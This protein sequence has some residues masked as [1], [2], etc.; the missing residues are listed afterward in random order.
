[1]NAYKHLG[2]P[3][4]LLAIGFLTG[5]GKSASG[6]VDRGNALFNDGKFSEAEINYRKALQKDSGS[7]DASYHLALSLLKQNKPQEAYPALLQ[8]LRLAPDHAGARAE[9]TSLALPSYV[10]DE[11]HPKALYDV[12]RKYSAAW[13]AKDPRSVD[14]LRIKAYLAMEERRPEE[15]AELFRQALESNPKNAKLTLGL[16]DALYRNKQLADAEK[17]GLNFILQDPAAGDVYDALYR[18]YEAGNRADDAE[19]I[20]IRKVKNNPQN[21]SYVLEL[22]AHYAR[23]RQKPQMDAA[24][25]SFLSNPAGGLD[26]HLQAGDFYASLGDWSAAL[27]QYNAG[28]KANPKDAQRYQDRIARSLISQGKNDEGLKA[29]NTAIGQN[30]E[31]AE[32][33]A[34][35]AA[36]LIGKT[37]GGKPGEGLQEFQ[38]LVD[39]N[40]D[41]AFLRFVYSK[42]QLESGNL[43]GAR[44]QL[45]ELLKRRP[46]FA[47]AQVS[48]ADI[49]LSKGN[50]AQAFEHANAALEIDP[51]NYRAQLIRG[52]ASLRLGNLDDAAAMLG[53]LARLA[54][55][56]IDVRLQL[57]TLDLRRRKFADA[58]AAF[59]KIQESNSKDLRALAGLVDTDLAQNRPDK[60]FARL[61]QELKARH[62]AIQVRY[63]IAN[64]ALKTGNYNL[65]IEMLQ[66]IAALVPNS[67]DPQLQLADVYRRRGDS[68]NAINILQN[69]AA[70]RP[71]DPRPASMLPFLLEKENRKRDAKVQ[72]RR[73]LS[74]WPEDPVSMNNLAFLLADTGENL[75]EALKLAR[76]VVNKSPKQAD[77]VDTLAYVY[78]RRDQN[79]EAMQLLSDLVH[80]YPN[81]PIFA[82]HMGL[83]W[84]QKGDR[85][86]AKAELTRALKQSPPGDVEAGV[87]ELLNRIN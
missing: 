82:Y 13:L 66:Q 16:I 87:H 1:M 71:K 60:A 55:E 53:R 58:E 72:A 9:F 48:L 14:G 70:L 24:L 30:P 80:R 10:L 49:E 74:L 76:Q 6:Y 42:A 4:A 18:L 59:K 73:A 50:L 37:G 62:G 32:A 2:L 28:V 78:L 8:T 56:S 17:T 15:A 68:R 29:L 5:C 52:S 41:D 61:N 77:F 39:K 79:D 81:N 86:R 20:L 21:G 12:L 84:Y 11:Q 47:D 63:M 22:A 65:T 51:N 3:C 27:D 57:A 64:T 38:S 23:S 33:R 34:L 69:A 19:N 45:L 31:D 85:M 26:V 40:P 36:L 54:P 35:R 43:D 25:Q 46:H 75:D 7:A 44:T 67:I 83:T